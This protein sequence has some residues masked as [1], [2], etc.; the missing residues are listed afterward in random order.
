MN[1]VPMIFRGARPF[2]LYALTG[3]LLTSCSTTYT[4]KDFPSEE[5]YFEH[6]NYTAGNKSDNIVLKDDSIIAYSKGVLI[7]K[8]SLV[9]NNYTAYWENKTILLEDIKK[10]DYYNSDF[11][12]PS[13]YLELKDGQRL[14][15]EGIKILQGKIRFTNIVPVNKYIPINQVDRVSYENRWT[16]AAKGFTAGMFVSVV[17]FV[18]GILPP[19][20]HNGWNNYLNQRVAPKIA[21]LLIWPALGTVIGYLI[22]HT[23]TYKF[24]P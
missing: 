22:G 9:L 20:K 6:F 13:A 1:T 17:L 19:Y 3:L 7:R 14:N 10:I 16:T 2:F 24:D 18:Y 15:A 21:G 5:K 23:Y 11:K 12:N 8:D 4:L